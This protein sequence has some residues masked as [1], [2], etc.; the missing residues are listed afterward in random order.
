MPDSRSAELIFEAARNMSV[1]AERIAYL[2]GACGNDV[3]LRRRVERL[4]AADAVA[5]SFLEHALDPNAG[6][7]GS[8]PPGEA[9]TAAGR[10]MSADTAGARIG[11]Y[12]LV[13]KIGEGGMGVVWSADQTEPVRRRV[14]LKL[15]KPGMDTVQVIRRFETERQALALMDHTNI[16]KVF[17]A[18]TT[19]DHRPF[20]VMELIHG[21]PI[22]SHCDQSQLSV[23]ERLALFIPICHAIQHAH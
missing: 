17:D 8:L 23:R 14:A 20:F 11:P 1:P 2:D 15:I 12:T 3:A 7:T 18:G 5:G 19:V 10:A 22:T 4:L 6:I 21:V 16:A 9:A 13:E